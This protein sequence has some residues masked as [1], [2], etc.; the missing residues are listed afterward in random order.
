[1]VDSVDGNMQC[2]ALWRE[3]ADLKLTPA[4]SHS[5]KSSET[6]LPHHASS[7]GDTCANSAQLL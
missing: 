6:L 2:G 1:M 5:F 4:T 3:S 7:F